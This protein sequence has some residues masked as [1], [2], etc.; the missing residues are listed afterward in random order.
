MAHRASYVWQIILPDTSKK[1]KENALCPNFR[2]SY[3]GPGADH[4]SPPAN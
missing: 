4:H 3:F 2:A 1:E